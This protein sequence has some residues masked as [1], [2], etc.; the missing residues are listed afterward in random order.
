MGVKREKEDGRPGEWHEGRER[1]RRGGK[2]G[3]GAW[4]WDVTNE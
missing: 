4:A 3:G 1:G 2:R